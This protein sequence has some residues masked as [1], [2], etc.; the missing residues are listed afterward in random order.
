MGLIIIISFIFIALIISILW[1]I[2]YFPTKWLVPQKNIKTIRWISSILLGLIL[3][4]YLLFTSPSYNHE[5]ASLYQKGDIFELRLTGERRY[6][7]H[8]PISVFSRET[9]TD[10]LILKLPR[11]K[12][13]IRGSEITKEDG[14]PLLGSI[15][16]IE[17][18]VTVKLYYDNY[19]DHIKDPLTYNGKYKLKNKNGI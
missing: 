2:L 6:M 12:G 3:I 10:T 11:N 13:A 15:E 4:Y 5:Y 17:G 19:D 9:Y 7:S 1:L 16:I 14:Y 18:S 8:D